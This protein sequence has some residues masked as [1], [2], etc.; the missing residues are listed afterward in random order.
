[1]F[2]KGSKNTMRE[3]TKK[4][5]KS[6][7]SNLAQTLDGST[8]NVAQISTPVG[9]VQTLTFSFWLNI[10]R[11][12]IHMWVSKNIIPLGFINALKMRSAHKAGSTGGRYEKWGKWR[13]EGLNLFPS[14]DCKRLDLY[15]KYWRVQIKTPTMVV[16][17]VEFLREGQKLRHHFR[18]SGVKN[19][20]D[21]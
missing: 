16:W 17:V 11:K 6:S 18:K 3:T 1:M 8:Q 10:G 9:H 7:F 4:C 20:D 5:L 19:V 21:K 12:Y 14:P 2:S 13:M 15:A